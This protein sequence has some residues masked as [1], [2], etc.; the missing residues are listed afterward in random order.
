MS[1]SAVSEMTYHAKAFARKTGD[2]NFNPITYIVE[3]EDSFLQVSSY[4]QIFTMLYPHKQ[5]YKV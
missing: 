5:I 1:K 2:L 3:K 4:L